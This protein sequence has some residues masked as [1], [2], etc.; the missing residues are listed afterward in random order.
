M[1]Q[2]G[3]IDMWNAASHSDEENLRWAWLRAVEWMGWPTFLSQVFAPVLLIF[4]PWHW[5]LGGL[6]VTHFAWRNFVASRWVSM[7]AD[8]GP[9]FVM[10]RFIAAPVSAFVIWQQHH[11]WIAAV[12]LLWPWVAPLVVGWALLIPQSLMEAM[13]PLGEQAQIGVIQKRFMRLL[14]RENSDA[15]TA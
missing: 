10:L 11:R 4:Y 2:K 7:I 12:A 13:T 15:S 14:G 3:Y 9:M 6:I 8:Q 5:V 1:R